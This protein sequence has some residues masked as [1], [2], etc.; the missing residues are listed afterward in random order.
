MNPFLPIL[1]C[2]SAAQAP[3]A[4]DPV[5]LLKTLHED[6][7]KAA[8]SSPDVRD[9]LRKAAKDVFDKELAA[10]APKTPR[11]AWDLFADHLDRLAD[12]DR[13]PAKTDKAERDLWIASC[14]AALTRL[15]AQSKE[16]KA[17]DAEM[18]TT[19]QMFNEAVNA[20]GDIKDRFG[21]DGLD[22]LRSA[23]IDALNATYRGLLRRARAPSGDPK[24]QYAAQLVKIDQKFPIDGDA[25]KKANN[26]TNSLLKDAAK[27]ALDRA[28]AGTK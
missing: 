10:S 15:L 21:A 22:D 2:L 18:P 1:L 9:K 20:A 13:F 5:H 3:P 25:E 11:P 8:R 28:L 24:T 12:A 26:R 6:L 4:K 23:A 7:R 14:K 16:A 19:T 27:S 17:A